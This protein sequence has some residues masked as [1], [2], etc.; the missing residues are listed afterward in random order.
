MTRQTSGKMDKLRIGPVA[1]TLLAL[2]ACLPS[3]QAAADSKNVSLVKE[4]E[5]ATVRRELL[6]AGWKPVISDIMAEGNDLP[7]NRSGA[8]G[9]MYDAGYVEVEYCSQ[10]SVY[11]IFHYTRAGKCLKITTRGEYGNHNGK[12]YPLLQTWSDECFKP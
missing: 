6:K 2:L 9:P 1:V 3:Q 7:E 4:R 8:A 12:L 10:G 5:F 11:C